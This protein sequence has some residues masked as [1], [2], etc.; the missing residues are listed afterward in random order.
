MALPQ[1]LRI[2]QSD[3]GD[4][5]P[6]FVDA[7]ATLLLVIIFLLAVF[8][9]GQFALSQALT[10]RDEQLAELNARLSSLAEQLNMARSENEQLS[11]QISS[12]TD[13]NAALSAAN[14]EM[15]EELNAVGARL[16]AVSDSLEEEEALNEEAQATI[17]LLNNQMAA[18][19]EQLA[20]LNEALEASEA[21]EE[22]L[23]SQIVNLGE[24]LNA[25]LASQVARLARYRSE[26]FGRLV[27]I[28][29]NRT[30]VRVVGDRFVFETD[31]LFQSASATLSPEGRQSL[32]PIADAI[33]QLTDEIPEDI[34]WILRV[35]GHTD[36][37]PLGPNAPFDSNF[38]LSTARAL[39]V[40]EAFIDMGVPPSRLLAAGFGEH[41]PI[42]EGRDPA[43]LA[44][45]R[46][47]ELKLT[48]R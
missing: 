31:V 6:G 9:A 24:R 30:G 2:S 29:G 41:H 3:S 10:G 40:V 21:R 47:I 19:R 15:S 45:N 17:T 46:R 13:E 27:E 43:S 23:E 5:W 18:L 38:E 26:F 32:E 8:T 11:L 25:A 22:E 7:L 34:D 14:A 20:R 37:I 1:H 39:S 35:D 16:A 36:P 12:L 44:R 4:Y 33:I 48:D 42:A 28:L